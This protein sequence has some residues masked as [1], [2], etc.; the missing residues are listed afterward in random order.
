[1]TPRCAVT[2]MVLLEALIRARPDAFCPRSARPLVVA[3]CVLALKL[4]YDAE[5]LTNAV[6]EPLE[7]VLTGISPLECARMEE[8]VL[9]LL[10]WRLP[11]DPRVYELYA[12]KL[13][14]LGLR[15]GQPLGQVPA[16]FDS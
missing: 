7:G 13:V 1:M 10:D 11:N 5:V 8:Q 6:F 9:H 2:A 3:T 15:P 16:M 14:R 12:R 4:T